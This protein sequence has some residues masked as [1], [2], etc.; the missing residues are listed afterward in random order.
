MI[1]KYFRWRLQTIIDD[2]HEAKQWREVE[3]IE[4]RLRKVVDEMD[5]KGE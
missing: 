5:E 4:E 2:L 1:D 3:K